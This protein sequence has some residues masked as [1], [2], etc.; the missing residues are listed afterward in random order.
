MLLNNVAWGL[1]ASPGAEFLDPKVAVTLARKAVELD[2]KSGTIWNTLGVT[3]YRAGDYR[4]TVVA[5]ERSR[6]LGG[7]HD[8][9]DWFFL[10]MAH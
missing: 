10:A 7:G 3:H 1:A 5:L 9:W 2:P 6:Q 4:A 8:S